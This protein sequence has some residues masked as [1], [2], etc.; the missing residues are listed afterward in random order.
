MSVPAVPR[1]QPYLHLLHDVAFRPVFII[2]EHRSGTTILYKLL[3]ATGLFNYVTYYH[4]THSNEL[5]HNRICQQ[6]AAA[7][8]ALQAR[9]A[10]LNLEDRGFDQ[11]RV[12]PERACL[13]RGRGQLL[14][15]GRAKGITDVRQ[16]PQINA[17]GPDLVDRAD[18][19]PMDDG[20]QRKIDPGRDAGGG[21]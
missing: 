18:P 2:G 14:H 7:K 21:R 3:A 11:I 12:L 10:T 16:F 4:I 6:E 20:E 1:D 5:L 17:G 9:F 8:E 13:V 19:V 15:D